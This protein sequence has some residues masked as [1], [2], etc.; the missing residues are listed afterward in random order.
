MTLLRPIVLS[1]VGVAPLML[2]VLPP[3][4]SMMELTDSV[5]I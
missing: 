1:V 3:D 2:A 5:D 4:A